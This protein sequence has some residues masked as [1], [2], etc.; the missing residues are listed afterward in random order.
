[1]MEKLSRSTAT[2]AQEQNIIL[3]L[4]TGPKTTDQL[5]AHG[6]YQTSARIW[7]LRQRGYDIHTE[8]YSGIG[9]DS[10]FHTRMARYTLLAEP[11]PMS[12]KEQEVTLC[13]S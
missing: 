10:Y 12:D 11:L 3:L 6:C 2:A 13:I 1:M 7:G 5:R 8:L 9:A 4:R